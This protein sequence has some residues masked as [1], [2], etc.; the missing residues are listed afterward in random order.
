MQSFNQGCPFY[1]HAYVPPPLLHLGERRP[2]PQ[3]VVGRGVPLG[4][5][6]A[7]RPQHFQQRGRLQNESARVRPTNDIRD[8]RRV[9]NGNL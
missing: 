8:T 9:A 6:A 4:R 2:Q 3:V 1:L 7:P 5:A